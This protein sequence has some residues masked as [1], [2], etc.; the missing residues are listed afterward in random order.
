M[1]GCISCAF[2]LLVI[3][4][5][6]LVIDGSK[7]VVKGKSLYSVHS[8]RDRLWELNCGILGLGLSVAAVIFVT[9]ALKNAIGKP[10][11]DMLS[12]CQPKPGSKDPLPFGLS[13]YSICTGDKHILKDGFKSFPSGHSST[14]FA[15]LGYLSIYLAG[16]LHV[17]DNRGEVWKTVLVVTP[18]VAASLV[19]G[20]RI[21]DARHHPFDVLFGSTMG[22]LFAWASYRQYFPPLSDTRRHGRAYPVRTWG[23]Q[24]GEPD[25]LKYEQTDSFGVALQDEESAI[26]SQTALSGSGAAPAHQRYQRGAPPVGQDRIEMNAMGLTPQ[27]YQPYPSQS[28]RT[29]SFGSASS[30]DERK[31]APPPHGGNLVHHQGG[32]YG[33]NHTPPY[34]Q[35][36]SDGT[37]RVTLEDGAGPFD[38]TNAD[39]RTLAS[40]GQQ[41]NRI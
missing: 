6:A 32:P 4:L 8:L 18:L 1:A 7:K 36:L 5:Y 34:G 35:D 3:A 31:P 27:S 30:E 17:L 16:K 39:E 26:C 22:L 15:G 9:G 19:A 21:M 12:R 28:Y 14:A 11:P 25:R 38:D 40:R 10:R 13:D 33:G 37:R 41:V 24:K 2:P 23:T 29:D 20:S